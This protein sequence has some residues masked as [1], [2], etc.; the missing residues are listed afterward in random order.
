MENWYVNI[1]AKRTLKNVWK[2]KMAS[3][4]FSFFSEQIEP[5]FGHKLGFK[6]FTRSSSELG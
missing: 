2:S 5:I 4:D 3:G 1:R 6:Q